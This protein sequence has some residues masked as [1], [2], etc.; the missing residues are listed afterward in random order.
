MPNSYYNLSHW[1]LHKVQDYEKCKNMTGVLV[2]T[3]LN[4]ICLECFWKS[5]KGKP[6]AS[7]LC[8]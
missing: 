6:L 2:R 5:N 1:G 4:T 3:G 8:D 7:S